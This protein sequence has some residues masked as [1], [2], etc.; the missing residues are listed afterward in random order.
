MSWSFAWYF[1]SKDLLDQAVLLTR[2]QAAE[3][4]STRIFPPAIVSGNLNELD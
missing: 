3:Y 1:L 4:L 2:L